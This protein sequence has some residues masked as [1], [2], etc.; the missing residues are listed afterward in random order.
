MTGPSVNSSSRGA[1]DKRAANRR[2]VALGQGFKRPPGSLREDGLTGPEIVEIWRR[3]GSIA[4]G[5]STSDGGKRG[6]R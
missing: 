5:I 2:L 6:G 3:T 1:A 4:S